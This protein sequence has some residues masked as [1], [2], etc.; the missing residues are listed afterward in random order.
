MQQHL[1]ELNEHFCDDAQKVGQILQEYYLY[2]YIV[3]MLYIYHCRQSPIV[4]SYIVL[5]L[6]CTHIHAPLQTLFG[7]SDEH[8]RQRSAKNVRV[9]CIKIHQITLKWLFGKDCCY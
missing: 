1:P 9:Y 3:P 7:L 8:K 6:H 4:V 2:L 5:V